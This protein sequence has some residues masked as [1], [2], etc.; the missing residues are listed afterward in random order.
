MM[1][2]IR[3]TLKESESPEHV[4][5]RGYS[6]YHGTD[7]SEFVDASGDWT[8][9]DILGWEYDVSPE[10]LVTCHVSLFS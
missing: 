2:K 7:L 9:E 6:F 1:R 3:L 5:A 10:L 4:T 8:N